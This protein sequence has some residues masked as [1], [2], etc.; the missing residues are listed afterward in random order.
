[1]TTSPD[2][3]QQI[4]H[5]PAARRRTAGFR[6]GGRGPGIRGHVDADADA[7]AGDF[8]SSER[9]FGSTTAAGRAQNS[10]EADPIQC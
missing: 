9:L 6:S 10:K 2:L 3:S 1:M 8:Q 4:E 7:D 5:H